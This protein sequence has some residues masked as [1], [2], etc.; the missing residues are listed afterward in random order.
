MAKL[1]T[2]EEGDLEAFF[3]RKR[4]TKYCEELERG[5]ILF[6]PECPIPFPKKDLQF[7]LAQKQSGASNR[8][9]IAYKPGI[10]KITNA[11]EMTPEQSKQLLEIMQKYS[12]RVVTFLTKLLPPYSEHW[13]L[14]YAS[15]RPF[16][17]KGRPLRTRARNDLLH[18][19]S[20]PTR[21]LN[22][23]RILRFFT[24]I[25]PTESRNWTTSDPFEV[26][27]PRFGGQ[28]VPF[29]ES[30]N[31]FISQ[32]KKL[33]RKMALPI[34]LRSPY[35]VFMLNLHNHLK[36]NGDF[37]QNCHKD[38]WE[39]PPNSCWA[40]FTDQVSHAATA[41]QYALEQTFIVPPIGLVDPDKAPIA[42]LERLANRKMSDPIFSV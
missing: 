10:N 1:I 5:N 11:V 16:Q 29:P 24:N 35:D 2:I 15:Y 31:P 37:Q 42:V 27:A 34:A 32:L 40:V 26:L 9:N 20:F 28:N 33:G 13:K 14:D 21:P 8:K 36:E 41:G 39:F 30:N 4:K 6:F 17:E 7:L 12:K 3:E 22:G 19:D 18:V 38:F 23:G 25:N